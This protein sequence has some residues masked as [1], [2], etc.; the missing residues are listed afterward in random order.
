MLLNGL[1]TVKEALGERE[2]SERVVRFTLATKRLEQFSRV[3]YELAL[4]A[5]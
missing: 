5:K 1:K 2:N 4:E 3:D